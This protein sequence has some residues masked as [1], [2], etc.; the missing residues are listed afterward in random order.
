MRT[1]L[2]NQRMCVVTRN[3]KTKKELI[4]ITNYDKKWIINKA[5]YLGRSFYITKDKKVILKFLENKKYKKFQIDEVL[6][7]E[8][9][10]YA[11]NL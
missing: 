8:L 5:T 4:Q 1:T 7:E 10:Q 6:K 11:Q 3:K 9:T 2:F